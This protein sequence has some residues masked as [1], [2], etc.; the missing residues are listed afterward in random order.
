MAKYKVHIVS[1]DGASRE[2]VLDATDRA[3]LYAEIKARGETLTLAEE[4]TDEKKGGLNMNIN[5]FNKVKLHDKITF[6][7]SLGAMIE[8]GLSMSRALAVIEKQT[9]QKKFKEIIAD[10]G[11]EI[12]QGKTLSDGMKKYEDT[13]TPLMISM[14]KAGE[15]S[16]SLAQ[17]LRVVSI[18]ME[19]SYQLTRKIKGAMMYPLIIICAMIVIGL[20]MLTFVV[21][22]L[23]AT[24]KEMN[25]DL[26]TSTKMIIAVSEFLKNHYIIALGIIIA[27]IALVYSF[28]VSKKGR[29]FSD[30]VVLKLPVISGIAKQINSAR[31]TRTMSSLLSAGVDVVIATHITMDVVQNSYYKEV[32]ALVE[33][34]IQKGEPIAH[35]FNDR[36]DLYP[37]FVGEMISVGEETG[38]LAQMLLGVAVYYE[39]EIDQKTKDMSAIIEPLLMV[40]IGLVVGLF[41]VSIISPIYSLGANI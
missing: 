8:A 13:F 11:K 9:K 5:L 31:T 17:S 21:P 35:V 19:S 23:A 36:E 38:Q 4:V 29:R 12:S 7:K 26:P 33:Q 32:L 24:F 1:N 15:E 34:K 14:V 16:G 39:A 30:Y 6:T 41:A 40:I 3:T 10:L 28:L 37:S 27:A 2:E 22:I 20:L 25:A 18:Q